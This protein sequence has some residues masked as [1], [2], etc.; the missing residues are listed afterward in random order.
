MV[1]YIELRKKLSATT[2]VKL[3]FSLVEL[4]FSCQLFKVIRRKLNWHTIKVERKEDL[5]N[6]SDSKKYFH[7]YLFFLEFCFNVAVVKN[8]F[9]FI[10]KNTQKFSN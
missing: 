2:F 8:I 6:L 9:Y 5:R 7:P 1:V 3:L 4:H 10:T